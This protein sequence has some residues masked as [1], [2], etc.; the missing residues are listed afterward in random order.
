MHDDNC[1][2]RVQKCKDDNRQGRV[3]GHM[4]DNCREK[5]ISAGTTIVESWCIGVKMTIFEGDRMGVR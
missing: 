5:H 4:D 2:W 1:R 3:Q